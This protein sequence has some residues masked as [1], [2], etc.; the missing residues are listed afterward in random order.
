VNSEGISGVLGTAKHFIG[1][2][3][4]LYGCN[5]GNAQVLNFKSFLSRNS[6][7]FGGAAKANVGSVMVSYSS[8]NWI[9]N[10]IN[11][12]FLLNTLRE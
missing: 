8:I 5:E 9:P 2:G 3:A 1:D 11:S 12:H 4:T 10:A 7:G 6:R